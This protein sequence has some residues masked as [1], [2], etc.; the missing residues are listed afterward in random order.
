[1]C[2]SVLISSIYDCDIN[3]RYISLVKEYQTGS[4][5]CFTEISVYSTINIAPNAE[6][7][8]SGDSDYDPRL[9][10]DSPII[11]TCED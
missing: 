2:S 9:V 8:F 3:G 1:M 11:S 5:L 7:S 10:V 6:V 4:P